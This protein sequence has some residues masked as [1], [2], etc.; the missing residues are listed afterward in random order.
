MNKKSVHS[1]IMEKLLNKNKNL[2]SHQ[3]SMVCCHQKVVV[4]LKASYQI[5][6][7]TCDFDVDMTI[8]Q[9]KSTYES[10]LEE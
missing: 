5:L 9:G 1:M 10:D 4:G 8:A 6:T 3:V 7:A 2:E